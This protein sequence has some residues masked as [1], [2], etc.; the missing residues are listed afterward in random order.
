MLFI[1]TFTPEAITD[2]LKDVLIKAPLLYP[3]YYKRDYFLYLINTV[4]TISMVLVQEEDVGIEHPIY[5]L[6]LNLNDTEFKYNHIE[7]LA[8][9]VVQVV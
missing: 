7:K 2:G 4:T 1:F 9:A 5:Y 8:L 6:M 3:P